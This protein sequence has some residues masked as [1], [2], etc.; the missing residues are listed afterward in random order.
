MTAAASRRKRRPAPV[1][2]AALAATLLAVLLAACGGGPPPP[3]PPATGLPQPG[4]YDPGRIAFPVRIN[5]EP[6]PYRF[7]FRTLLPGGRAK[8]DLGRSGLT[9]EI[10]AGH[11]DTRFGPVWTAPDR[12]GAYPMLFRGADGHV[13]AQVM[14]FVLVPAQAAATGSIGAYEIGSYREE[15]YKGFAQYLPPVG[16]IEVTEAMTAMPVS[17]HFTLGQFLAKQ[18]SDFPKYL[19]LNPDLLVKLEEILEA[20]NAAGHRADGLNVM[21]GYRTPAYN[22]R[23]GSGAYSRHV[24]GAAADIFPDT[25]PADNLMDDLNRDGRID[26]DDALRLVEMVERM[27]PAEGPAAPPERMLGGVAAYK[28][29]PWHGPFV[30]V[31]VR[32]WNIRWGLGA[33]EK[34]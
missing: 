1:V 28:A 25:T 4:D 29:N 11:L 5:G 9:P 13:E 32:G 8:I 18:E 10:A 17:P 24:F 3:P 2:R 7:F 19:V 27:Y 15:P 12:P 26:V 31:D 23:I 6:I 14:M 22:R 33:P 16:Y 20:L 21:S 34:E 30:H